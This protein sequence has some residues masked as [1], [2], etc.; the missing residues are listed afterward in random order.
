MLFSR[1]AM[2]TNKPTPRRIQINFNEEM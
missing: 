1:E 2:F